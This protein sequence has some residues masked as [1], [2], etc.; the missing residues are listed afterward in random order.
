MLLLTVKCHIISGALVFLCFCDMVPVCC[1]LFCCW[2]GLVCVSMNP[3]PFNKKKRRDG[4]RD[5]LSILLLSYRGPVNVSS[6]HAE[7]SLCAL[8]LLYWTMEICDQ[9]GL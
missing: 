4:Q 5:L 6:L 3:L 8:I 2:K 9:H 1:N 7:C